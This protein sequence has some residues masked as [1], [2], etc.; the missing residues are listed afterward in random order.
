MNWLSERTRGV[1]VESNQC[2]GTG[3][4]QQQRGEELAEDAAT[5]ISMDPPRG[6]WRTSGRR[7]EG[8]RRP[9]PSP[10][11]EHP[12]DCK[13]TNA[14]I[15]SGSSGANASRRSST[16]SIMALT[17]QATGVRSS[18]RKNPNACPD[19]WWCSQRVGLATMWC[20]MAIVVSAPAHTTATNS[21][22]ATSHGNTAVSTRA[23]E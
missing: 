7:R 3:R 20:C 18:S 5:D 11:H 9:A 2:R 10:A 22:G 1:R 21:I 4:E 19:G 14:G 12:N 6:T 17:K 23:L 13:D 15:E 8:E 16:D